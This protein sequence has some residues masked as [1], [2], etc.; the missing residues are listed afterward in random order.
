MSRWKEKRE[1]PSRVSLLFTADFGDPISTLYCNEVGCVAGTYLGKVWRHRW[2]TKETTSLAAY[3]ENAV[4]CVYLNPSYDTYTLIGEAA[5][6]VWPDGH[7]QHRIMEFDRKTVLGPQNSSKFVLSWQN[8]AL[9][10]FPA[11]T[12]GVNLLTAETIPHLF[13]LFDLHS[14]GEGCPSDFD[15]EAIVCVCRCS[16]SVVVTVIDLEKNEH[17]TIPKIPGWST[18]SIVRLWGPRC[19]AYVTKAR[20]VVVYNYCNHTVL[21]RWKHNSDVLALDASDDKYIFVLMKNGSVKV[22]NGESGVCNYTL[23]VASHAS[24]HLRFPYYILA[25]WPRIILSCDEGVVVLEL[26]AENKKN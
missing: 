12:I 11:S 26:D 2:D 7:L 19:L 8:L 21:H 4:R 18:L 16:S 9:I 1:G 14:N 25:S 20:I 10:L 13:R 5:L 15:G 24:F 22:W 3:S 6:Q 17:F 23:T